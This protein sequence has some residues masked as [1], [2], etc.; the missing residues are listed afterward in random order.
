MPTVKVGLILK[1][2]IQFCIEKISM[3]RKIVHIFANLL[4]RLFSRVTV[5][6][7]NN[8]PVTG[9]AILA[10]NHL[11]IIDAPLVFAIVSRE[12]LTALVAKDHRKNLFLR[13]LVNAVNGIWINRDEADTHA[14]R[15]AREHLKAGGMLGIAPEGTRSHTGGLAPAKTGVVYLA[16][17]TRVPI[18]PVAVSGTYRWIQQLLLLRRPRFHVRIGEPLVLPPIDRKERD[19]ALNLYTDELMY[20]IAAMLPAQHQGVYADHPRTNE[21]NEDVRERVR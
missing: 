7:M 4:F 19:Q 5:T 15:A 11:S 16:N 1:I 14:V 17:L 12:D 9:P 6:G 2:Q 21:L 20:R 13:F 18:I 10:V 8:L 3:K